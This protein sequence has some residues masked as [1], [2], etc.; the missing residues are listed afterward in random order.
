[1]AQRR[2]DDPNVMSREQA[3]SALKN[4][5]IS[6]RIMILGVSKSDYISSEEKKLITNIDQSAIKV[7]DL[8]T[9]P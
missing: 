5:L 6:I 3:R 9:K 7:I 4:S 8:L 2:K 1:M